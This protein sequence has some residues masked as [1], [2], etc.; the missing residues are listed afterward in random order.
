MEWLRT[1][2]FREACHALTE[3]VVAV[4]MYLHTE[5]GQLS[6][7]TRTAERVRSVIM[8]C[9]LFISQGQVASGIT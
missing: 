3:A 4:T 1:E 7:K 8:L 9:R 5:D 6:P 2:R